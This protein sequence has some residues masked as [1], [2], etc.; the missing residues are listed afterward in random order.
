[1]RPR[2]TKTRQLIGEKFHMEN[3]DIGVLLLKIDW[4]DDN[5]HKTSQT[6][7]IYFLM[8]F[9]MFLWSYLRLACSTFSEKRENKKKIHCRKIL[10]QFKNKWTFILNIYC[11][12]LQTQACITII[13][14]RIAIVC[15]SR[16]VV[17]SFQPPNLT[18][19]FRKVSKIYDFAYIF[20]KNKYLF[21]SF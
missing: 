9:D 3:I 17:V 2:K 4:H 10:M 18:Y 21:G 7:W 20:S 16:L 15:S 14:L 13:L 8:M 19:H 12:C 5:K 6:Y 11:F 1:M